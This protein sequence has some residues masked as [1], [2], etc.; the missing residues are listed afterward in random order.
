VKVCRGNARSCAGI[1]CSASAELLESARIVKPFKQ[2]EGF[3]RARLTLL[4]YSG[5]L[6]ERG[7]CFIGCTVDVVEV[8]FSNQRAQ[9]FIPA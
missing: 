6:A 2:Q 8:Y 5:S 3:D 4:L 9:F 7:V 1:W